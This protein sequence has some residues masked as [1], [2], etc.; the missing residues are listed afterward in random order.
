MLRARSAFLNAGH[1]DPLVDLLAKTL[2]A[3]ASDASGSLYLL[4]MGCGEGYY[5]KKILP[6]LSPNFC[7][8]GVDIAKDGLQ[9]AAKRCQAAD[10][11]CASNAR[12]PIISNSLD[13]ITRIFAPSDTAELQRTLKPDGHLVIVS[14]GPHHL[15]E[16]KQ[17]LYDTVRL[18]EKIATP[19]G[20]QLLDEQS[21]RFKL[22][23]T[24]SEDIRHLLTMTPFFWRGNAGG[25]ASLLASTQLE[26]EVHFQVSCFQKS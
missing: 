24:T 14:P 4:D 7:A 18:H 21:L 5:L 12:L 22:Q 17:A 1:F 9:L 16:I 11:V 3:R 25:R 10:W 15:T 6:R 13:L 2:Q 8:A 20:F 23:L 19:E 26:V